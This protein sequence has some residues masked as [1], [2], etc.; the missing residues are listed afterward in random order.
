[1]LI[2]LELVIAAAALAALIIYALLG[3]ADF[4]GGM[5]DLLAFGPRA[6][7]QR[8]AIAAAIGP[9]WEANHVWLVLVIVLLFT[10]FPP[11]FAAGMTALNIPVM[12][13][14]VGIVLRGSAFAFRKYGLKSGGAYRRWSV[15]FGISSLFTPFFMGLSIGALATGQIRVEGSLV[16]TGFTA[17]WTAPFAVVCGVFALGL[18]AFLSAVYLTVDARR[19]PDLQEDFRLRALASGLSLAPIALIVFLLSREGAPHLFGGLTSWWSPLLLFWT[20]VFAVGALIALW[21]R[22]YAWARAAAVG[23]VTLILLGWGLAQSPYLI[24]PDL[25]IADAASP[26]ATLRLLVIGL[27]VGATLLFPSLGY[28]FYI[29]KFKPSADD[30]L[31]LEG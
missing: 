5:W 18:L 13:V 6:R 30:P 29:F 23:Q 31:H 11:A 3:G 4:G 21:F 20:S 27:G 22:R 17:G 28:L 1:M 15:V 12:V 2:P 9:I 8:E 10:A 24:V 25:T 7:Q 16:T 26:G 19:H 14:L